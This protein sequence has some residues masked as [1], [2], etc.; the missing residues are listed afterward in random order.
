MISAVISAVTFALTFA[1]GV[2]HVG[3]IKWPLK[4]VD[5]DS[6]DDYHHDPVITNA[7]SVEKIV[8]G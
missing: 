4:E 8:K 3:G 6:Q 5:Y 1:V 2:D 7:V